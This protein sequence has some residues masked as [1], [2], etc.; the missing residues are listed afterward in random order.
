MLRLSGPEEGKGTTRISNGS[1]VAQSREITHKDAPNGEAGV[2]EGRLTSSKLEIW[3][4]P[5]VGL[6]LS[7]GAFRVGIIGSPY[8][9]TKGTI[10]A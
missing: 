8:L 7:L 4:S 10:C 9:E 1:R 6:D 5:G 3:W 2:N